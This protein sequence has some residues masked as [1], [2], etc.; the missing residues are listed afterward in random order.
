MAEY[1]EVIDNSFSF[2]N[3]T[4]KKTLKDGVQYGWRAYANEG[5]MMYDTTSEIWQQDSPDSEPYLVTHYFTLAGFP[6][7][8]NFDNFTWVAVL[9]SEVNED[10]IFGGGDN[11]DHE[12][13]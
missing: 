8:Y 11:N 3:I 6:L 10:Y 2:P 1:T 5:Y 13:M 9:R 7:N 4:I 12:N